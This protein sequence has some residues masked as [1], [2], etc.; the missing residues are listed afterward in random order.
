MLALVTGSPKEAELGAFVTQGEAATQ[1]AQG[2]V[3]APA[4]K[5]D[6]RLVWCSLEAVQRQVRQWFVGDSSVVSA[7]HRRETVLAGTAAAAA[8]P[9]EVG[10]WAPINAPLAGRPASNENA[11]APAEEVAR[12]RQ[13]LGWCLHAPKPRRQ[14]RTRL[15]PPSE[16]FPSP[17]LQLPPLSSLWPLSTRPMA[18]RQ[19]VGQETRGGHLETRQARRSPGRHQGRHSAPL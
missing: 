12:W 5:C 15:R 3:A 11:A 2:R 18:L 19:P 8:C 17:A 1:L 7:N 13:V 10:A 9:W 6:V 14:M 4:E 16:Q